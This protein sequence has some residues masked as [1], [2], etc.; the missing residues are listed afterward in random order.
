MKHQ[1]SEAI[2][3]MVILQGQSFHSKLIMKNWLQNR[4][5]FILRSRLIY[6]YI[7]KTLE[8]EPLIDR[9]LVNCF[10]FYNDLLNHG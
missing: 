3:F 7:Y 6:I 5:I 8:I 1:F 2:D 10:L 4:P 9:I